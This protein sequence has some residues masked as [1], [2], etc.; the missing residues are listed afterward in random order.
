MM[1]RFHE[2]TSKRRTLRFVQDASR[3]VEQL[4]SGQE[5]TDEALETQLAQMNEM[6]DAVLELSSE[7]PQLPV[8]FAR[9]R[10]KL[11]AHLRDRRGES[12]QN[13]PKAEKFQFQ[14]LIDLAKS[15][16]KLREQQDSLEAEAW[17]S[18]KNA[19]RGE[20]TAAEQ[21]LEQVLDLLDRRRALVRDE[22]QQIFF[23]KEGKYLTARFLNEY[24][25]RQEWAPALE[26][27]ERTKSRALLSQL[28]LAR[29]R[30]PM[31]APS[32]LTQKEE[33][34]LGRARQIANAARSNTPTEDGVRGFELWDHAV[35]LQEDLDDVWDELA[36]DSAWSE[37]VSLRRGIA[38]DLQQMRDCLLEEQATSRIALLSYF[39][40]DKTTWLFVLGPDGAGPLAK[41][42]GVSPDHLRACDQRLL[43]D[44]HGYPGKQEPE[45]KKLIEQALKLPPTIPPTLRPQGRKPHSRKLLKPMYELTYL[46]ELSDKLLPRALHSVLKDCAVLC[47]SAHG[48][49]HSLPLH[50]LRWSDGTYLTERFGVCYVPSVGVLR[51]CRERNQA[52]RATPPYRPGTGLVACVDMGGD[53]ASEFEADRDLLAPL[54]KSGAGDQA[55]QVLTGAG[56]ARA[57]TKHRVIQESASARV[58]HLSCHGI[59]ASD[60]GW[61][62]P[63]QSGLLLA[64][65]RRSR[66][67]KERLWKH[68]EEFRDCLL[69]ARETYNLRL[70]ADLVTLGACSTG[71]A[72]VEAGDDL[73]G[74]SRAW[75]YAGTPSLLV[76]LWNVD[77]KSS[78]RLLQVFYQQWLEAG[79]PKWRALQLAQQAL[80]KDADNAEYQHPFHWAP[81]LV[82]GDWV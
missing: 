50:A 81:F 53:Q 34:L 66:V 62:D 49:L 37:Y 22:Q 13:R 1:G 26:L 76:S 52:R 21:Q 42:T 15:E 23:A 82:I 73:L 72:Q 27:V 31:A 30:K 54:C 77:T 28:G 38:L 69:T 65:G 32:A 57:A 46:D 58:I 8:Q 40:D 12:V 17:D 61:Q 29:I 80:L 74:L 55:C 35:T 10:Q 63:L 75:L 2:S 41:D 9:V 78:H 25:R 64:D 70:E 4:E 14:G 48:P 7:Y 59:F 44:F 6:V 11:R 79:Q 60:P 5:I 71:R 68:P 24:L 39:V 47:I 56:G 19:K 45:Q 51:Y 43:I 18:L 67:E 33:N 3:V 16:H 36:E 20:T